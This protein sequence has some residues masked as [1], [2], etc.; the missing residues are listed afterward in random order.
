MEDQ[1]EQR[2]APQYAWTHQLGQLEGPEEGLGGETAKGLSDTH[3]DKLIC[4]AHAIPAGRRS[5]TD[6]LSL[7]SPN[8]G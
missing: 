4:Q 8:R 1:T 2:R 3:T 5:L 7:G 6:R